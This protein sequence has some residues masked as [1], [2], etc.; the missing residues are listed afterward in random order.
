MKFKRYNL[1]GNLMWCLNWQ[2]GWVRIY[3]T[4]IRWNTSW[5]AKYTY[6]SVS[7]MKA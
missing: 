5:T 6:F 2:N 7:N 4:M 1:K 3:D